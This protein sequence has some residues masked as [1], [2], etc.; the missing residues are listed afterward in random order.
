[1]AILV[2]G[3]FLALQDRFKALLLYLW[4]AFFR[5]QDW[6]WIDISA[7]KPSLLLGLVLVVLLGLLT[8]LIGGR[9]VRGVPTRAG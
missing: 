4:F 2:P 5:P 6:M 7:A 1:M 9:G 8:V 3:F